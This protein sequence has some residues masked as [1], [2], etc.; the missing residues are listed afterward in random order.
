MWRRRSVRKVLLIAMAF[1]VTASVVRNRPDLSRPRILGLRREAH[2]H[3]V[4]NSYQVVS[5]HKPLTVRQDSRLHELYHSF[6]AWAMECA[7][8]IVG[9][10]PLIRGYMIPKYTTEKQDKIG[11]SDR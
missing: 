1:L 3:R 11:P 10:P 9:E 4:T 6:V 8:E 7:A 5:H 2:W